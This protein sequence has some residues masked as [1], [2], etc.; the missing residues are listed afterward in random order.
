MNFKLPSFCT[1]APA[2]VAGCTNV[3]LNIQR[4]VAGGSLAA[5]TVQGMVKSVCPEMTSAVG[6]TRAATWRSAANQ[7]DSPVEKSPPG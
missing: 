4:T 3:P 2:D 5:A 1:V 6:A 7:Q